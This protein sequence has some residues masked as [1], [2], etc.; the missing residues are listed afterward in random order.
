MRRSLVPALIAVACCFPTPLVAQDSA[1]RAAVQRVIAGYAQSVQ[2]ENL[3]AIEGAF[4]P[5]LH[6]LTGASALHSWAEYRDQHLRPETA[7][8]RG[9]RYTHSGIET[10]IRGN[11]AWANFRWQMAGDGDTP[12]P[13]LGRGTAVLE[14]LDGSWKIAVLHF[15]R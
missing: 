14:K 4:A 2:S 10:T 12:A 11:V 6:I 5:G 15:S 13:A 3:A 1:E 7:R 8:F 9:L